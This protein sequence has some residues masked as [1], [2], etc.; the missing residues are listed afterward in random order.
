MSQ[1]CQFGSRCITIKCRYWHANAYTRNSVSYPKKERCKYDGTCK[2][3]G[4][5]LIHSPI[6]Y[7]KEV[8]EEVK[9]ESKRTG[10]IPRKDHTMHT[11][12]PQTEKHSYYSSRKPVLRYSHMY[13]IPA[14]LSRYIAGFMSST[15]LTRVAN[16]CKRLTEY[17]TDEMG[18]RRVALG[19][20]TFRDY[21]F[22]PRVIIKGTSFDVITRTPF[23]D[24]LIRNMGKF[25]DFNSL[26]ITLRTCKSIRVALEPT[27]KL[28]F[29]ELGPIALQR[30]ALMFCE[31][32]ECGRIIL[33][34]RRCV[35][36]RTVEFERINI[37]TTLRVVT[38]DGWR[39]CTRHDTK[40]IA[41]FARVVPTESKS[42]PTNNMF[43]GELM[44]NFFPSFKYVSIW[45]CT[46]DYCQCERERIDREFREHWVRMD[47]EHE[48][49]IAAREAAAAQAIRNV[50]GDSDSDNDSDTGEA[51]SDSDNG[52]DGE[53]Y[54]IGSDSD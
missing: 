49:R 3:P 11:I 43:C 23:T 54:T 26:C 9:S 13:S 53:N 27:V 29:I 31:K 4:C 25:L 34:K 36:C 16:T 39:T 12:R 19:L 1:I 37:D 2:A 48:E 32:K 42:K 10:Y 14:P 7:Y 15:I 17:Y 40:N 41:P 46:V 20:R 30:G 22:Q 51:E 44:K 33:S 50:Q 38:C 6:S 8:T 21:G 35:I 52:S 24:A 18:K 5:K 45:A 28:R 47:R